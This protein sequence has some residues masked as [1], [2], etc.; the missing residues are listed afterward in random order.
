MVE[1]DTFLPLVSF[2]MGRNSSAARSVVALVDLLH[3]LLAIHTSFKECRLHPTWP[4]YAPENKTTEI[5]Y[6]V[7]GTT[8]MT[9]LHRRAPFWL[10]LALFPCIAMYR[11]D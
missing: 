7:L 10:N 5:P 3:P 6:R 1:R 2:K 11:A 9:L 4:E 8:C